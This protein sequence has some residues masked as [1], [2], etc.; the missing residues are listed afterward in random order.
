MCKMFSGISIIPSTIIAIVLIIFLI[1]PCK[2]ASSLDMK[3]GYQVLSGLVCSNPLVFGKN[4]KLVL[5][6]PFCLYTHDF[7]DH[8]LDQ[9]MDEYLAS[10][11]LV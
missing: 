2:P 8:L 1:I 9:H 4:H 5:H 10:L 3:V 7:P 6:L 11:Y